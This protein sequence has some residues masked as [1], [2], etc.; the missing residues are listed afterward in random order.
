VRQGERSSNP[1]TDEEAR[2][3]VLRLANGNAVQADKDAFDIWLAA[4]PEHAPAYQCQLD[5]HYALSALQGEFVHAPRFSRRNTMVKRGVWGAAFAAAAALALAVA[6]PRG[7]THDW[8]PPVATHVA[9]VRDI[10]LPD[11]SVVT[12]GADTHMQLAFTDAERRVQLSEGEAY[13]RVTRN[14]TRP[15]LIETQRALVR[16][17]GTEFEIKS[18]PERD[19]VTVARGIVEVTEPERLGNILSGAQTYRLT[20]GQE[21][22]ISSTATAPVSMAQD[23]RPAAWRDGFLVYYDASLEEIVADANRY[24]ETPIIIEDRDLRHLRVT[25]SY[26]VEQTRRMLSGLERTLPLR[27]VWREDGSAHLVAN[28]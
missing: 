21:V 18:S 8:S 3:W 7:S 1:F 6:M 20:A 10:T 15:F 9:E 11:G 23:P 24:S 4:S 25:A 27:V 28:R 14:E 26:P 19:R 5:L 12:L 22:S 16:V 17:V 2:R 13:F